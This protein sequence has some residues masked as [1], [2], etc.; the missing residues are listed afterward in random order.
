[1]KTEM[2]YLDLINKLRSDVES[3]VIPSGDK[4]EILDLLLQLYDLLWP[5]SA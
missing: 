2:T 1:M 5:Y 3:D 4:T